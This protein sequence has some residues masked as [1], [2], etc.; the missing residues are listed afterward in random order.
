MR[1]AFEDSK[2]LRLLELQYLANI[3]SSY[4]K[5]HNI[6][7]PRYSVTIGPKA[8]SNLQF[9]DDQNENQMALCTVLS[10]LQCSMKALLA[11]GPGP[12]PVGSA[13]GPRSRV[14][15]LTPLAKRCPDVCHQKATEHAR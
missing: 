15:V 10:N 4:Y 5:L 11:S 9:G 3:M 6:Q 7:L 2:R 13:S 8:H 14:C 12:G 1:C